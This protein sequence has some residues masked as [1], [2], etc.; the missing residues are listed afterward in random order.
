MQNL[1]EQQGVL[2][3]VED[4]GVEDKD[5]LVADVHIKLGDEVVGH[6]HDAQIVSRPGRIGGIEVQDLDTQLRGLKGGELIVVKNASQLAS[7][8]PATVEPATVPS[9]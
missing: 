8:M 1:R 9:R 7:G 6:Q 2:V 3:P 4:R 5:Y